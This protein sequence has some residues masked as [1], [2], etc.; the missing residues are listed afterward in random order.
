MAL[1]LEEQEQ[2]DDAKAWWKQHGN[3]VIWGVTL[4]LVAVAGWRAWETWQRN[5]AASASM[6]FDQVVQAANR[7]DAKAAKD[8]AAQIMEAHGRSAYATPAAWL[9][10]HINYEAGD[11]KS[12]RAQYEYAMQHARDD[13][14][15]QLARLRL[16][17]LLFEQKELDA[18]LKQLEGAFDPAF[19]GLEGQLRGDILVAQGKTAEAREAYKRALEKLGD[20]SPL[21]PLVEIRLDGLGG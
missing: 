10:G 16:A 15:R 5:Q 13:G 17:G 1:D 9:A 7:G 18:A 12:A 6:L 11:L 4:F 20:N 3:K 2:L 19:Q 14:A 21:K 8:A